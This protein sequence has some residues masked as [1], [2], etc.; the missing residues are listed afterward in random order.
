LDFCLAASENLTG[1][2][3]AY[4]LMRPDR[5]IAWAE[6]GSVTKKLKDKTFAAKV[7]RE[8]I[9]DI[10]RTGMQKNEFISIALN[11]MKGIADEIGL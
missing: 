11:A 7:N 3:V 5:R 10:E 8:M 9:N 4:V 2:I 6:T 1:I